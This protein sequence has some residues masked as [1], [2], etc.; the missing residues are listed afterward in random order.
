MRLRRLEGRVHPE[1]LT[2]S[3]LKDWVR[4]VDSDDLCCLLALS[5]DPEMQTSPPERVTLEEARVR[6]RALIEAAP[7]NI[8]ELLADSRWVDA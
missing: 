5:D 2:I 3:A 7:E 4:T 8:R 1:A 6:V